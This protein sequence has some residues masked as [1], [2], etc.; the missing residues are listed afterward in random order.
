MAE[1]RSLYVQE[2][3]YVL[4][5]LRLQLADPDSSLV[6][7]VETDPDCDPDV[8][9]VGLFRLHVLEDPV[10]DIVHERVALSLRRYV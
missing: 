2:G 6:W 1:G 4:V 8:V 3:E 5:F 9:G 10:R 7:L